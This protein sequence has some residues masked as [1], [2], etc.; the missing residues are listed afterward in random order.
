MTAIIRPPKL[1]KYPD[2][3]IA[4]IFGRRGPCALCQNYSQ[5]TENH[6][7]PEGVGNFDQWIA[8][9]YMTTVTANPDMYFGRQFPG[10]IRF[11]TLC[12]T[13]NNSLGGSED[14]A[15]IDFYDRVRK[16]LAT[17][18]NLP[19]LMR[20]PAK[21]NLIIRGLLAHIASANDNGI[22]TP[23]DREARDIFL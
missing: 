21:P 23:F 3:F 20:V 16:L 7:P 19:G 10:G 1:R 18:L 9:S 17:P 5:L 15:L 13:C 12:Q 22:P 14:R 4:P 11:R 8:Q 6:V 2:P